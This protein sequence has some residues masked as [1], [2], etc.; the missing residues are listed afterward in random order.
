M[1]LIITEKPSVAMAIADVV[2]S[3]IKRPGYIEGKEYIVSWCLGHLLELETPDYYINA[4]SSK[5][6]WKMEDLPI[7]PD[8]WR[9]KVTDDDEI[10]K[11]YKVIKELMNND[12][13]ESIICATDAGIEG[14]CIFRYVY[15]YIKSNKYVERL[16]ISSLEQNAIRKALLC[17]KPD[18]DYDN[19]Y[20]AGYS[21][22]RADW[23]IGMNLTRLFSIQYN[24]YKPVLSIGRVQTPTLAMIVKRFEI[25][26]NFEKED[27]YKIE[28]DIDG[29]KLKSKE[30]YETEREAR[31]VS[32][33]MLK[34]GTVV[35]YVK[36]YYIKNPPTLYDLTLLQREANMKYGYTAKETL[37]IVQKLYEAKIVTYPRTDSKYIT[38]DM[39]NTVAGL[40]DIINSLRQF[41]GC[42]KMNANMDC[43]VNDELVSDHHAILPT[44]NVDDSTFR[45]LPEKEKNILQ[46][47][48]ERLLVAVAPGMEYY[49]TKLDVNVGEN[50][51]SIS[52]KTIIDEGYKKIEYFCRGE[53][54][55]EEEI[56]IPDYMIGD[57]IKIDGVEVIKQETKPPQM[58]NDNT[59]LE[60]MENAGNNENEPYENKGIGTPATRAGIIETLVARKY[61]RR[62]N[63]KIIPTERGIKLISLVPKPLKSSETTV[64]WENALQAIANGEASA[65]YFMSRIESLTDKLVSE[66]K[67]KKID[68]T[69]FRI[70]NEKCPKCG[71]D[72]IA[73]PKIWKCQN[74]DFKIFKNIAGK[75]ITEYQVCKLIST[76]STD[77]ISGFKKKSGGTFSAR[78][79]MDEKYE[80]KF[81]F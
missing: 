3:N 50:L 24:S 25:I 26:R 9:L 6:I 39:T 77:K 15:D 31:V 8:E 73:Y 47:L 71:K 65:E 75:N 76:G 70:F 57:E 4:N 74:C 22:A 54:K 17:M 18:S 10:R 14:E 46:M 21:R 36:K 53:N 12:R 29:I 13:I 81:K 23:L 56:D 33:K 78:L 32:E 28:L 40:L 38:E 2:G 48:C 19:L 60:A 41:N 59:L 72:I 43:I 42:P 79:T 5:N 16:W 55:D 11:Q 69:L 44:K 58:Y 80:V 30:R 64:T 7:I 67:N 27:Y 51:Y 66:Q 62:I 68:E 52:K 37:D 49:N 45:K 20:Y 34:Y 35:E 63:K 61:V 1:K